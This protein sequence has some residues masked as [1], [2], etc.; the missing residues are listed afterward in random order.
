MPDIALGDVTSGFA[1]FR[2][3]KRVTVAKGIAETLVVH[4]PGG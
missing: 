1:A 3:P 4:T 2:P